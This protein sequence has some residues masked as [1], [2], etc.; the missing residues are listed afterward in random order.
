MANG[1][2]I[3]RFIESLAVNSSKEEPHKENFTIN[4]PYRQKCEK[5]V[6]LLNNLNTHEKK[7][8]KPEKLVIIQN[9]QVFLK[10]LPLPKQNIG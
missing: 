3:K 9:L 5:S 8:T 1:R 7:R 4:S 10:P 2:D 6:K